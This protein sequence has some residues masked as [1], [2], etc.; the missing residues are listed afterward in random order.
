MDWTPFN[1]NSKVVMQG[2]HYL[3]PSTRF[4]NMPPYYSSFNAQQQNHYNKKS[5]ETCVTNE[6]RKKDEEFIDN[7]VSNIQCKKFVEINSPLK[8]SQAKQLI[9]EIVSLKKNLEERSLNLCETHENFDM[10]WNLIEKEMNEIDE[11]L[12]KLNSSIKPLKSLLNKRMK[13]RNGQKKKKSKYSSYKMEM[14]KQ[15]EKKHEMID[16]I[17]NERNDEVEAIKR[18]ASLKR[19]ADSVLHEVR[20]KKHEGMKTLQLLTA[21]I[22]LRELR[23]KE[24]EKKGGY[25]SKELTNVFHEIVEKLQKLWEKQIDIYKLEEKGLKIMLEETTFHHFKE[26]KFEMNLLQ[27]EKALFGD[28]T[29]DKNFQLLTKAD[30]D[31]EALINVRKQW[32]QF[33]ITNPQTPTSSSSSSSSTIPIGW[34]LPPET[35]N[36]DWKKFLIKTKQQQPQ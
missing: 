17:L 36:E 22:K 3:N 35:S 8:I 5:K 4:N 14:K 1:V 9:S 10:E 26:S 32:D 15:I 28:V 30:N 24:E 23:L 31:I 6:Q 21:L 12:V 27:W 2:Y 19:Q 11:K 29:N 20:R 25:C 16:K 34:V 13:K 18:E 33:L 7:F